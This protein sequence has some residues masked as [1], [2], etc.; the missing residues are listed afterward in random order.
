MQVV[1]YKAGFGALWLGGLLLGSHPAEAMPAKAPPP[2]VELPADATPA[3]QAAAWAEVLARPES[4]AV[5]QARKHLLNLQQHAIAPLLGLMEREEL[6][7]LVGTADLI[8]PGADRLYGHGMV[9]PYDIDWVHIRAGWVLE[10]VVQESFGFALGPPLTSTEIVSLGW[11]ADQNGVAPEKWTLEARAKMGRDAVARAR[12][13]AA[14]NP[15]W[16]CLGSVRAGLNS[17]DSAT[18]DRTMEWMAQGRGACDGLTPDVWEQELK[19][20]VRALWGHAGGYT[21]EAFD[22]PAGRLIRDGDAYFLTIKGY[23]LP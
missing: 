20:V 18:Q 13:W 22:S 4:Y 7:D 19:P 1:P 8:Y 2:L 12:Q 17:E 16:T 6:V 3:E 15:A 11:G 5:Y 14:E 9:V 10:E 21:P 23:P